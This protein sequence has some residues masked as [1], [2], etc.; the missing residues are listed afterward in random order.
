M[1]DKPSSQPPSAENQDE[2]SKSSPQQDFSEMGTS[3]GDVK[4]EGT[5]KISS[6]NE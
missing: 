3:N 2:E 6:A 5:S 1:S 4:S